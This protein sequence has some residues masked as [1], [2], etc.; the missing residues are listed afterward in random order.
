VHYGVDNNAEAQQMCVCV[1]WSGGW[2]GM[3]HYGVG[4]NEEVEQVRVCW[5]GR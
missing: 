2:R 4:N 5:S 1:C 3:V